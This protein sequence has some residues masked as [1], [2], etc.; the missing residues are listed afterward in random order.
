M[1][2][3][4]AITM[5]LKAFFR[6]FGLTNPAK[7]FAAFLLGIFPNTLFETAALNVFFREAPH[8]IRLLVT[9]SSF[10]AGIYTSIFYAIGWVFTRAVRH[11]NKVVG[12][13]E[14]ED[15]VVEEV[16]KKRVAKHRH[17]IVGWD[18]RQVSNV[19][20]ESVKRAI[21]NAGGVAVDVGV[22]TGPAILALSAE[23]GYAAI[24]IT[25]SH[26]SWL[27]TGIKLTL[28][29]AKPLLG[30]YRL[31]EVLVRT[32]R[33]EFGDDLLMNGKGEILTGIDINNWYAKHVREGFDLSS[34]SPCK[35]AFE[36]FGLSATQETYE[37]FKGSNTELVNADDVPVALDYD[38]G[39]YGQF[40]FRGVDAY[41]APDPMQ[42]KE[43]NRLRLVVQQQKC[44]M[45]IA[46]DGD[47]DR[48]F[49]LD[50]TGRVIHADIIFCIV[51]RRLLK[52][53]PGSSI[54]YDVRS[55]KMVKETILKY[56]GR[57]VLSKVGHAFIIDRMQREGIALG[58]EYSGHYYNQ[59]GEVPWYVTYM[60]REELAETGKS[61]DQAVA[62][63][64]TY[65]HS[66]EISANRNVK[67]DRFD[68]CKGD[69]PA[70]FEGWAASRGLK[71]EKVEYTDGITIDFGKSWFNLRG[72]YTEPVVRL[73]VE[74]S[75]SREDLV[76]L[77][78]TVINYMGK[79]NIKVNIKMF[80][81]NFPELIRKLSDPVKYSRLADILID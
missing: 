67:D 7:A 21:V 39:I 43:L 56:G 52:K 49:F 3:L 65:F 57:P 2:E 75:V 63:F 50:K 8:D 34:F 76:Q 1:T 28:P 58:G 42:R 30:N 5:N 20:Y 81:N 80:S 6:Q 15:D 51:I 24:H 35:V 29:G 18:G 61:L 66:D 33:D 45:G 41:T 47:G 13:P 26:Y 60:V 44:D 17:I 59:Y 68:A 73:V 64:E 11:F 14:A 79:Y 77:T 27:Y 9:E 4:L 55:S 40:S 62:E 53:F 25:A 78:Q 48:V 16:D 69:A 37:C 12:L 74:S 54:L 38:P 32:E 36:T 70:F 72:S 22:T 19:C 31:R 23:L 71:I 46:R 10:V